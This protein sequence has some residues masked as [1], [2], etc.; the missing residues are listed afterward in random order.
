[1]REKNG[2]FIL[3]TPKNE[4]RVRLAW[5]KCGAFGAIDDRMEVY[6]IHVSQDFLKYLRK[7]VDEKE[8]WIGDVD[9]IHVT[10]KYNVAISTNFRR[11]GYMF[12]KRM[13]FTQE[14]YDIMSNLF[15]RLQNLFPG[16]VLKE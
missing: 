1:M 15:N 8:L 3:L 2:T 14:V 11:W 13:D 9:N 5:I 4:L 10:K 7:S 12:E 6:F 16:I